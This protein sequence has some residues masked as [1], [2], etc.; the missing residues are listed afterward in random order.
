MNIS[1]GPTRA[2]LLFII[3]AIALS[4]GVAAADDLVVKEAD[5]RGVKGLRATF[6]VTESRDIVFETIN[7]LPS[8]M[9][10]F[11]EIKSFKIVREKDNVRDVHFKVDAV[12]SDAE[13]TLRR[14]ATR[15]KGV[16]VISWN[17]ISG[18]ANVIR[19]AWILEDGQAAGTTK[20]SYQSFVDVSA[21]VPTAIVRNVAMDKVEQMVKR[22]RGACAK[23]AAKK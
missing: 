17:R 15:K 9:K 21:V 5:D 4:G 16:D 6:S 3:G 14:R 1:Q 13:Y 22:L 20:I 18:D 12:I 10:L 8:F 19:G 7:D 23:R 11:P 2:L